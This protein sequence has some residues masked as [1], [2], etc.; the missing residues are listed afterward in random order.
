MTMLEPTHRSW[1]KKKI[2]PLTRGGHTIAAHT[3]A[4]TEAGD[5]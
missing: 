2:V 3:M 5:K 4:D 1:D